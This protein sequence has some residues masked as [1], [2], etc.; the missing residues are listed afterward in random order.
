MRR[1]PAATGLMIIALD[2]SV[3]AMPLLFGLDK[4]YEGTMLM[5]SECSKTEL[6]KAIIEKFTGEI[7]H[8]PPKRSDV[9]RKPRTRT[10]Y[11]FK[12]LKTEGRRVFF[13][14]NC[15]A[16]TYIRKLCHDLG[17]ELGC[18]A[19]LQNL[20]RT[21]IGSIKVS[22]ATALEDIEKSRNPE[23][24]LI[25]LES[26]IERVEKGRAV[27]AAESLEK[28]RHGSPLDYSDITDFRMPE[29][30]T[31]VPVYDKAGNIIALGRFIKKPEKG[32]RKIL[33]IERVLSF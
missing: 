11:F 30:D 3:K 28:V 18:G 19:H 33:R 23:N 32:G 5:H 20:R 13:R 6:E 26:L 9:A 4:E 14:V 22:E 2:E 21:G 31:P 17:E 25:A 29:K 7:V 1:N 24:F 10:I 8:T 27:A 16:G 15:E 12:I